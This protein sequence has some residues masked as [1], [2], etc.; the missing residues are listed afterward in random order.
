MSQ[1]TETLRGF[2]EAFNRHDFDDAIRFLHPED[3]AHP[4]IG[5]QSAR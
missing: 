1:E 3:E 2:I 4:A 5:G